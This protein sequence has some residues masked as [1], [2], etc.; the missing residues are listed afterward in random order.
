MAPPSPGT[1]DLR[2]WT[3]TP[4]IT[5]PVEAEALCRAV[6][7][8]GGVL[9]LL[10]AGVWLLQRRGGAGLRGHGPVGRLAMTS[11]LALDTRIRLVLVRR[12]TV[13]HL[14]AVGPSG[15]QLLETIPSSP[16]PPNVA[17]VS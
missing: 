9:I 5:L 14:L 8:L 13:E 12:D 1:V 6:S 16:E 4:V 17:A 10:A 3:A 2:R 15:V 11:R 7:A